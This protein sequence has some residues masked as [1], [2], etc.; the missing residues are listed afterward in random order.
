M[1]TKHSNWN[2][3]YFTLILYILHQLSIVTDCTSFDR[4]IVHFLLLLAYFYSISVNKNPFRKVL[5]Q[6]KESQNFLSIAISA[7]NAPKIFT[8]KKK[9]R[10]KISILNGIRKKERLY[11]TKCTIISSWYVYRV[12]IGVYK[13]CV[14]VFANMRLGLLIVTYFLL[15]NY[16]RIVG[17]CRFDFS[18]LC[19]FSG[20]RRLW[21][22]RN[23]DG[24]VFI[25]DIGNIWLGT[26][27]LFYFTAV[28][29]IGSLM[30]Q[31]SNYEWMRSQEMLNFD[32]ADSSQLHSVLLTLAF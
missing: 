5:N 6:N 29:K 25:I 28:L 2:R 18:I 23:F 30:F 24:R 26:A 22:R 27:F 9:N 3:S 16:F 20:G 13:W 19:R 11:S 8:K 12:C 31:L 14:C 17:C 32:F 4:N 1:F 15:V 10:K 21:W 7:Y